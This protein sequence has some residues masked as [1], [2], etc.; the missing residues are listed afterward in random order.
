MRLFDM[1]GCLSS[2]MD[3]VSPE[4]AGHHIRVGAVAFKLGET[5]GLPGQRCADLALAG[6]LHDMGA[7]ALKDRLSTLAFE[8]DDQ[9]HPEIGYRL[10]LSYPEFASAAGLVRSHHAAWNNDSRPKTVFLPDLELG[11]LLCLADRVETLLPRSPGESVDRDFILARIRSGTGRM[12]NPWWVDALEEL[13]D[14]GF[15]EQV[16]ES[17]AIDLRMTIPDENNPLLGGKDVSRL[18]RLFSQVIDFRC[19]FT[20]THSRGVSATSMAIAHELRMSGDNR[21]ALEV[22]SELHDLGKLGVPNEIIMKPAALDEKETATMQRHAEHG[23]NAL[24]AAP[25]LEEVAELVGQHHERLDGTG[26]PHGLKGA[27]IGLA[28]RVLAVSDVFTAMG[29]DRPYRAGI[30]LHKI[31]ESLQ[32]L[33]DRKALDPDVVSTV[34]ARRHDLDGIRRHAQAQALKDFDHFSGTLAP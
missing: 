30:E 18:A 23:Y 32:E 17:D 10:L 29:E 12:F 19:R 34:S 4:V 27:R 7:F 6:M 25:G 11:N 21:D 28:S 24:S 31:V 22:A 8:S 14:T 13:V 1:V 33:A 26:Y 3:L 15:L 16:S 9:T 2:A 20:A 5:V